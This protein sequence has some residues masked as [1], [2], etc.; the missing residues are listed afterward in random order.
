MTSPALKFSWLEADIGLL[1]LDL[2]QRSTNVLSAAVLDELEGHLAALVG[3]TDLAGLIL[4]SGKPGRFLAGAD[5]RE[6]PAKL[7]LPLA[8]RERMS[9]RGQQLFG[10]LAQLP[11]VTVA[12]IDGA[13]V[14]GGAELA[15]WCDRRVLSTD[16]RTEIGFP[17]VK[18]GLIPGWGGTVRLPR[19]IGV[20][21]AVELILSGELIDSAHA[22]A[23]GWAD[24]RVPVERLLESAV[25]LIRTEQQSGRYRL[26]RD[27]RTQP[28]SFPA[29]EHAFL[30]ATARQQFGSLARGRSVEALEVALRTLLAG[31]AEE[32]EAALI[33]ES[34]AVAAL[35][36]TPTQRALLNVFFLQ[37]R[38][39]RD[40]GTAHAELTPGSVEQVGVVGAGIMGY[41]IAAANLRH[42]CRVTLTDASPEA[43]ERGLRQ[44]VEEAAY[45]KRLQ[46]ADPHRLVDLATQIT[47]ATS[48]ADWARC[49][50]VIEA[51]MERVDVKRE[52]YGRLETQLPPTA[53]LA[54]NTSTI[55]IARLAEGLQR[56]ERFCGMHFFNPVRKMKLVEIVRGPQTHDQTIATAVAHAKRIGKMPVVVNDGP[57]FLVNRL[58]SP[59]LQEALQLL[60]EG[61]A[62]EAIEAAAV[63]FGMPLGPFA[64]YDM[65]GIDTCALCG[66]TMWQAFPDRVIASPVL[67][68]MAKS[69]RLGQKSGRG[70]FL[71]DPKRKQLQPDP[72][73]AAFLEIYRQPPREMPLEAITDRLLLPM[74]LEA[75]RVLEAGIVRDPRDVDL[76]M[77]FGLGF[78]A[79]KGGLLYWADSLGTPHI[80]ERLKPLA[81]LGT[82]IQPTPLLLELARAGKG[83]YALQS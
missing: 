60:C 14:G 6:F 68:A 73:L 4:V 61:V 23:L 10:Q 48:D 20:G 70:F 28:V 16:R 43:L 80:L 51:V 29:A 64:L 32:A 18:I 3:R 83:F 24:D 17:E 30:E 66:R 67:N 44:A 63:A 7:D 75:T 27:R 74:L 15:S 82:R 72:T 71:H 1:S 26:D 65:V 25:R 62:I 49:G 2:P 13:C 54:S 53:V 59:Y 77:I 69:G 8:E 47:R 42:G 31:S 34:Q 58:L 37:D 33:R 56:P 50:L 35:F 22:L 78:P 41:S 40:K 46:A 19:L 79:E 45:E 38:N 11:G 36:G 81:H 57:G 55:P 12:A 21:N 52:V 5:L 39:K 76:G 9:R